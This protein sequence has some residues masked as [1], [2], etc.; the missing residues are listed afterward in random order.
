MSTGPLT[1]DRIL[2]AAEE[3]LR[4]FGPAKTTVVDVARALHVSHGS[5]YR[6]FPTKAALRDAVVNQWLERMHPPLLAV[7]SEDGPAPERLYRFLRTLMDTKWA[8]AQH[9]PE[10]FAAFA[11]LGVET[12]IPVL[13]HVDFVVAQMTRIVAAGVARG[14][15]VSAD[16]AASAQA[17]F[18]ATVRFHHPAH[19]EEWRLPAINGSFE[20]VWALILDGLVPRT[21]S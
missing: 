14:E 4:R 5:V 16:P 7:A 9:D 11:E 10:V 2:E 3:T 8:H 19:R 21:G 1:S 12:R 13:A 6:H 18:D 20:G 17:V 15:F